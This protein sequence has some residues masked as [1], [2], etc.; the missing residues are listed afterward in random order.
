MA[1][2]RAPRTTHHLRTFLLSVAAMFGALFI[3]GAVASANDTPAAP[4]PALPVCTLYEVAAA[5]AAHSHGDTLRLACEDAESLG[6]DTRPE[7]GL[8]TVTA[9]PS[10][11]T[12]TPAP[13]TET[14]AAATVTETPAPVT[15][16]ADPA[17]VTEY[18]ADVTETMA[19]ET[20][21]VQG[22]DV[23]ETAHAT[24]TATVGPDVTVTADQDVT[25][26]QFEDGSGVDQ[27]YPC[28]WDSATM[29]NGLGTGH[30]IYTEAP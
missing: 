21:T 5:D 1:Q 26:C 8:G 22:D 11:A 17:T 23:T 25:P 7:S 29:G 28:L 4:A 13:V 3:I 27:Q 30:T 10:T 9:D 20:I 18:P 2:H 16:T 6:V 14:M 12:V 19:P 24:V 15:T